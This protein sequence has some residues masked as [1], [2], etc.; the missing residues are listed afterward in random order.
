M[1]TARDAP[2]TRLKL[3]SNTR[4]LCK[5]SR[6]GAHAVSSS[7]TA[8]SVAAEYLLS[9][10]RCSHPPRVRATLTH[11]YTVFDSLPYEYTK[12]QHLR[13]GST[14]KPRAASSQT[15]NSLKETRHSASSG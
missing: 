13:A 5:H 7:N 2:T 12:W 9:F 3:A 8:D 15:H 4:E 14:W 11:L 6:S 1:F 10:V